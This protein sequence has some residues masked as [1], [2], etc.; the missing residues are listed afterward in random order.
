M[1]DPKTKRTGNVRSLSFLII[2]SYLRKITFIGLHQLRLRGEEDDEGLDDANDRG[3]VG[4]AEDEVEHAPHGLTKIEFVDAEGA[5]KERKKECRQAAL[6][7]HGR[8]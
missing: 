8:R 1:N 5:E 2:G 4:E 7:W 3:N 6:F